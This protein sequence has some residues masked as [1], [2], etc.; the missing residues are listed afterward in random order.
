MAAPAAC[1]SCNE[2]KCCPLKFIYKLEKST[3]PTN[4]PT[5]GIMISFT[6]EVTI[7]PK[8]PPITTPIAK[9]T[10]LPFIANSLNSFHIFFPPF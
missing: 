10:T 7:F 9:S 5:I 8:A 4:L 2:L 6:S 3:L 1:A